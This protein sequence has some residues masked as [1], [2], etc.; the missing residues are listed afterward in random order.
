VKLFQKDSKIPKMQKLIQL[1][2]VFLL[3]L[4]LALAIEG[5]DTT[6]GDVIRYKT[7]YITINA[8]DGDIKTQSFGS[9]FSTLVRRTDVLGW[10]TN[11]KYN[12]FKPNTPDLHLP[13][14]NSYRNFTSITFDWSNATDPEY[15]TPNYLFE[16]WND[17]SATNINMVNYTLV[18]TTNTTATTET[19]V[20]EGTFYWRVAA[21]DSEYNSTFSNLRT[22]TIDQTLPANFNLTSPADET[23]STDTTPVLEW[24][25]STDTNLDNYSIEIS[26][27]ADFSTLT[28][29]ENSNTNSFSSWSSP[30][31]GGDYYW[32]VR[33]A[34]KANNQKLSNTTFTY[35]VE[36]SE[37]A[38]IPSG[39]S[40]PS[41]SGGGAKPF[42]LNI[43]APE[44]I[45]I[46][47]DDVVQIPLLVTNPSSIQLRGISL[48]VSSDAPEII[49]TLSTTRI[50]S[51]LQKSQQEILLTVNTANA[52]IGT[53]GITINASIT[54][55][56]FNDQFKLFANL[57]EKE[58]A[59]TAITIEQIDFAKQL[60]NGNPECLD[61]SEYITEAE[62]AAQAG[63][64]A[65]AL[66]LANN[67]VEVCNKLL[68]Q[69]KVFGSITTQAT[70]FNRVKTT[71]TSRTFL[72]IAP[73][74]LGLLV[75]L[76]VIFH[77]I[78]KKKK[79]L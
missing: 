35:T 42:T 39:A 37:S 45:T 12:F 9:Y 56:K 79:N 54:N 78:R 6:E 5:N 34:D 60:F 73:Q 43:I 55:P 18:E 38:T 77:F 74:I 64:G 62:L 75:L 20:G 30:L 14:N 17:S 22:L 47:Q 76:G 41:T 61:L 59:G 46:Y 69:K 3:T 29:T 68:E 70:L 19:I 23:S 26:T 52:P 10:V 8:T 1:I 67:A 28:T 21:N 36:A 13:E 48:A 16:I 32:R 15:F 44:G 71:V 33:A 51:L 58:T 31:D 57:L 72:L 7:G 4:P 40:G 49:P 24:D 27:F 65:K 66:S 11:L 2:L 50:S 53:Y 63:F 25:S